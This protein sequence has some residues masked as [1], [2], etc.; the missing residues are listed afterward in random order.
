VLTAYVWL[1]AG[2]AGGAVYDLDRHVEQRYPAQQAIR[3]LA[4]SAALASRLLR[5]GARR[6]RASEATV[7][8]WPPAVASGT[9]SPSGHPYKVDRGDVNHRHAHLRFAGRSGPPAAK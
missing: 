4:A 1:W 7:R 3:P 5:W 2:A 8:R 9:A 6:M